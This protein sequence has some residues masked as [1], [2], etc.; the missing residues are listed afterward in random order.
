MIHVAEVKFVEPVI[1]S[2]S[3]DNFEEV[4]GRIDIFDSD[5]IIR[6]EF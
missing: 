3:K 2:V 4:V 6:F 5:S 1:E